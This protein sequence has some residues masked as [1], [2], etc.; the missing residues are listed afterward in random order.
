MNKLI[1]SRDE[2]IEKLR[3]RVRELENSLGKNTKIQVKEISNPSSNLAAENIELKRLL[4]A[5]DDEIAYLKNHLINLGHNVLEETLGY[6]VNG[7][8]GE[9]YMS[10]GIRHSDELRGRRSF[11]G[12]QVYYDR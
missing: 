10:E 12:Y 7:H 3:A 8:R 6:R 1:F 4:L 9:R 5:R 2:E 11:D